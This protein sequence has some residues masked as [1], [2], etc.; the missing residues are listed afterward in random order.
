VVEDK[1][2]SFVMAFTGVGGAL[3]YIEQDRSFNEILARAAQCVGAKNEEW[4]SPP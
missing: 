2:I 1:R 3:L 4:W